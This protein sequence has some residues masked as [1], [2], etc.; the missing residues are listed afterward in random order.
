VSLKPGNVERL[1]CRSSIKCQNFSFLRH[2]NL[3]K[4]LNNRKT[5]Q[6]ELKRGVLLRARKA[7]VPLFPWRNE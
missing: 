1:S 3:M 6:T 7:F 5:T 4:I 2:V